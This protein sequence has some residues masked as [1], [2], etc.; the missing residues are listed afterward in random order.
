MPT[1]EKTLRLLT[2][3][4]RKVIE[5][6]LTNFTNIADYVPFEIPEVWLIRGDTLAIFTLALDRYDQA[7]SSQ[8]F[9][10]VNM[11]NLYQQVMAAVADG[12]SP[13][14]AIRSVTQL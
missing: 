3:L 13:P 4:D 5:V 10:E 8:F 12:A 2:E 1:D 11:S 14:R 9:H 7:E 6:D